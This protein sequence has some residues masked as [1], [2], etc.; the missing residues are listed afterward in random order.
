MRSVTKCNIVKHRNFLWNFQR[1]LS[2]LMATKQ[3]FLPFFVLNNIYA[4]QIEVGICFQ[5]TTQNKV[6]RFDFHFYQNTRFS[7]KLILKTIRLSKHGTVLAFAKH[8]L[9]VVIQKGWNSCVCRHVSKIWLKTSSSVGSQATQDL[10]KW[11]RIFTNGWFISI[12]LKDCKPTGKDRNLI[13][14]VYFCTYFQ[15]WSS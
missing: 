7:Y 15:G 11:W 2:W 5:I 1:T 4:E 13:F 8:N 10:K 3:H 12:L 6:S 9:F 14:V